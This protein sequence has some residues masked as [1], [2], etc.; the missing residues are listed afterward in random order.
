MIVSTVKAFNGWLRSLGDVI[1]SLQ[2]CVFLN[3]VLSTIIIVSV[4]VIY[5]VGDFSTELIYNNSF[6][7]FTI[8]KAWVTVLGCFLKMPL[9]IF[10]L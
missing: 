2:F 1:N 7:S 4:I 10:S 8:L 9:A 5:G 3:C 6:S